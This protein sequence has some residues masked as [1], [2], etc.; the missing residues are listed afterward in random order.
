MRRSVRHIDRKTHSTVEGINGLD[1]RLM[2][3]KVDEAKATALALIPFFL[4][5][6]TLMKLYFAAGLS[7]ERAENE[8]EHKR[9]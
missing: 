8:Y 1:S 9:R 6:L 3:L 4:S 5:L 2:L 7:P